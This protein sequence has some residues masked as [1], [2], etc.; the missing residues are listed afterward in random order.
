MGGLWHCFNRIM[1]LIIANK[2]GNITSFSGQQCPQTADSGPGKPFQKWSQWD[3]IAV[4]VEAFP[5]GLAKP[6]CHCVLEMMLF[7]RQAVGRQTPAMPLK[8]YCELP[9]G[10]WRQARLRTFGNG[11]FTWHLGPGVAK[12]LARIARTRAMAMDRLQLW[13]TLHASFDFWQYNSLQN[14]KVSRE[15][16]PH[17]WCPQS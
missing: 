16:K 3:L 8:L 6:P 10:H 13:N 15:S 2:P 14:R 12:I 11:H 7:W 9:L 1:A 5:V 17:P 4:T